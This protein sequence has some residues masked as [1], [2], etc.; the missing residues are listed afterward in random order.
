MVKTIWDWLVTSSK[1]KEKLS[2]TIKAG[3]PFIATVLQITGH[4]V[5]TSALGELGDA[6]VNVVI[7][8][9]AFVTGLLTFFGAGRKVATTLG[10]YRR[11]LK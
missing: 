7:V 5:D 4:P 1:D 8:G 3:I 11:S 9:V 2:L 10:N 6:F